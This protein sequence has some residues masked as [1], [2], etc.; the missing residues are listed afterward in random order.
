MITKSHSN[1]IANPQYILSFLQR[2]P[3]NTLY[4]QQYRERSRTVFLLLLLSPL[5]L[6]VKPVS[7]LHSDELVP[8][9]VTK[10]MGYVLVIDSQ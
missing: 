1:S 8:Q 10:K 2:K 3:E 7:N 5:F 6:P 9:E 4:L